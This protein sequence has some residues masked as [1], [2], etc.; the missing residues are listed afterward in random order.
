MMAL[1]HAGEPYGHLTVGG[2]PINEAELAR[3]VG[4]TPGKVRKLVAELE[5]HKVFSRT[6]SGT[7][8]CRRMVRDEHIRTVRA[9]AGKL[10]GNPKLD[11]HNLDNDTSGSLDKQNEELLIQRGEQNPTPSSS[12]ATA[13]SSSKESAS[14]SRA[15][16]ELLEK[17]TEEYRDDVAHFLTGLGGFTRQEAWCKNFEAKLSGMHPPMVTPAALGAA[18]RQLVGNG[19][20]PNWK[21]FEGYL[22]SVER[23]AVDERKPLAKS[24]TKSQ[25]KTECG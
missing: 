23:A 25:R 22:R 10:G 3:M 15:R 20:R 5:R 11:G 14:A 21:L 4:E 7:I 9:E 12:S 18:V 24:F 2:E 8:Y 19:D 16:T 17:L 13:S 1:M 6:D